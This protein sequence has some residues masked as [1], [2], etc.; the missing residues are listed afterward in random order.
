MHNGIWTERFEI[1]FKSGL[2]FKNENQKSI[3]QSYTT[4]NQQHTIYFEDDQIKLP[5]LKTLVPVK[6]IG[7]SKGRSNRQRS[8]QK[9]RRVL[10]LDPLFGRSR[11]CRSSKPLSLLFMIRSSWS[12][13]TSQSPSPVNMLSKRSK[14]DAS[15]TQTSGESYGGQTEK[16]FDSGAKLS[17][18]KG[19]VARLYRFHCCQ[20]R[21]FIDQVSYHLVK[22][23]DTIYLEQ[24]AEDTV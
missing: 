2:A 17:E 6:S 13:P 23:Y 21:E 15:R 18:A 11:H 8:Q 7:R 14:A 24:I 3:W 20:K 19:K 9:Q 22:Q 10:H 16:S 1:T 5:K 4:N 12:K